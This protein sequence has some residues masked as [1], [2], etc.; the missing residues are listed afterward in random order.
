[1]RSKFSILVLILI[2]TLLTGC[3][4]ATNVRPKPILDSDKA[5]AP[6]VLEEKKEQVQYFVNYRPQNLPD[7]LDSELVQGAYE[8]NNA[9]F[10]FTYSTSSMTNTNPTVYLSTNRGK[11]WKPFFD[12]TTFDYLKK[13]YRNPKIPVG[14][15]TQDGKLYIDATKEIAKDGDL[16]FRYVSEDVGQTWNV[17]RCFEF[18]ADKYFVN[19]VDTKKGVNPYNLNLHKTCR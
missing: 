18:E 13:K 7:N 14:L 2:T 9:L 8:L 3:S 12:S 17:V 4:P 11:S 10:V 15:F 19:G 6:T 1:M 5:L 16:V